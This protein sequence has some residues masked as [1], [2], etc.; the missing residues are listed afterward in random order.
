[1]II[2]QANELDRWKVYP[3]LQGGVY[4]RIVI[5]IAPPIIT[6]GKRFGPGPP[7][8]RKQQ[9]SPFFTQMVPGHHQDS[10]QLN[11]RDNHR[12]AKEKM[13]SFDTILPIAL[14]PLHAIA[15]P[16]EVWN[17]ANYKESSYHVSSSMNRGEKTMK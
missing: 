4:F 15:I 5:V 6:R 12:Q 17:R 11:A 3:L 8:S 2:V 1:M 7:V 13:E 10:E 16:V 14:I 9:I